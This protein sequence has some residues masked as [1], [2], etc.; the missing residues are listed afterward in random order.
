M[1]CNS[2]LRPHVVWFG[3]AL[4]NDIMERT[5]EALEMCDMCLLVSE[6]C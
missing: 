3:E 6:E 5:G 2:L 1:K 4:D